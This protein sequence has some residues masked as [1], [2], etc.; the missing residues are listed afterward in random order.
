MANVNPIAPNLSEQDILRFKAKISRNPNGCW[1]WT[2]G[3]F[4]TGYGQFSVQH[5]RNLTTHRVA[6]FLDR[7]YWPSLLVCHKCDNRICVNPSH[8]FEGT[9]LD[10]QRDKIS[11]GRLVASS[12]DRNGSRTH[13]E[14]LPRGSNH[15]RS[16]LTE[17]S[18]LEI[19]RLADEGAM[20]CQIAQQYGVSKSLVGLIVRR[21]I[22]THI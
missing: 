19:R 2:G 3:T 4:S 11:K 17:Q 10:N 21:K 14:Q 15:K 12:G 8:L 20:N 18:V 9:P 13:P 7:G 22:W 6:F 1:E 16:K 5:A